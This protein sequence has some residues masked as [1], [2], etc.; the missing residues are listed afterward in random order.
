MGEKLGPTIRRLRLEAEFT[1]RG[2]AGA[3]G[4]S[5]AHQSD[6]EHGRRMPSDEV[7]RKTA[8]KLAKVGATYEMLRALDSRL[9]TEVQEWV[10]QSPE[11]GQM[12]RKFKESGRSP[13]DMLK[14]LEQM[15]KDE[16][17]RDT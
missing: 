13:R 12:L 9:G 15:L 8:A 17:G 6:I 3:I 10:R 2:F 4:I 11:V 7:L 5:A 1:L 14:Q 16:E